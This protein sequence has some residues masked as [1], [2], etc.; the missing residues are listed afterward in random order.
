[1]KL[2]IIIPTYKGLDTL[3][4]AIQ[5]ILFQSYKNYEIIVSDDNETNSNDQIQTEELVNKIK[6]RRIN[7][8]Y[9]KN[10]HHNG[11]YARNRGIEKAQG[12]VILL[13]DDD[14]YYLAG[15]LQKVVD[16]FESN[17]DVDVLFFDI[18]V[19]T[20]EKISKR[21]SCP[22]ITS[23][24]LVFGEKEIGTGSNICMK[25][26]IFNSLKFDEKYLRH[27]D[28]EF[29]ARVISKYK[30][31]WIQDPGI[32]KYYNK[33]DNYPRLDLALEMQ[34]LLRDNMNKENI[35]SKEQCNLL[36]TAQLHNLYHDYLSK[37]VSR[38]IISAVIKEIKKD[39]SYTLFDRIL[40]IGYHL[41]PKLFNFLVK[42]Y[43]GKR[44]S[45]ILEDEKLI[46]ETRDRLMEEIHNEN[47][48]LDK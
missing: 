23:Q 42:K 7:I 39:D 5:S 17:S 41:S 22:N 29:V 10:G 18:L 27:Q 8:S 31:C 40:Y 47:M 19:Y 4:I 15:H 1:M 33:I 48:L 11:S 6:S 30:F 2:S 45:N 43:V 44:T 24:T 37:E 16:F 26:R 12:D 34:Q 3:P 9:V 35:I 25:R 20:K 13:L 36:K 14:D 32:V 38:D 21:I 46:S 28:I